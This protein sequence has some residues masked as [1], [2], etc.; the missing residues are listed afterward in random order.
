MLLEGCKRLQDILDISEIPL[1]ALET[2]WNFFF[3]FL[4]YFFGRHKKIKKVRAS[5][6]VKNTKNWRDTCLQVNFGLIKSHQ[7]KPCFESKMGSLSVYDVFEPSKT[8]VS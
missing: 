2:W 1:V 5:R 3:S 8:Y 7:L 4:K 6:G